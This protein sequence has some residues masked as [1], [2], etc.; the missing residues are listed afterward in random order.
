[1]LAACFMLL[2]CLAYSLAL[3]M[4]ETCSSK[5]A[6]DFQQT[7]WPYPRRQASSLWPHH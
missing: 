1:L 4:E 2:S 5:M 3:N 6:V 7:K